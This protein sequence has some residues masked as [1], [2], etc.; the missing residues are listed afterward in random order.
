[1]TQSSLDVVRFMYV[2]EGLVIMIMFGCTYKLLDRVSQCSV[3]CVV[4]ST[5]S[6]SL[7]SPSLVSLSLI[8]V[9]IS[10]V[11]HGASK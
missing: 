3:N 5:S 10:P 11:N 8:L 6:S 9:L 4:D 7:S 1:M 2:V